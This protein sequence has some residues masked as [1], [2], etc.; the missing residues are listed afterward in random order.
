MPRLEARRTAAGRSGT[1]AR[2]S[3]RACGRRG[4]SCASRRSNGRRGDRGPQAPSRRTSRAPAR[5][6][7]LADHVGELVSTAA[8]NAATASSGFACD[9]ASA[10]AC[11]AAS[12]RPACHTGATGTGAAD[13]DGAWPFESPAGALAPGRAVAAAAEGEVKPS[14]S[15]VIGA[16][17]TAWVV[18]LVASRFR[19][20]SSWNHAPGFRQNRKSEC[21]RA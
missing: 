18:G 19:C 21:I 14:P 9:S 15:A 6:A 20:G 4:R 8:R 3:R 2:S 10:P 12:V 1:R 5:A 7:V 13:G 11:A 17:G 16:S